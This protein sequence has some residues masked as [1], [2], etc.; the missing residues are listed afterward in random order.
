MAR[1]TS[2]KSILILSDLFPPYS[3]GG[4]EAVAYNLSREYLRMG[5]RV[6]VITT[7]QDR[8]LSGH[9]TEDGLEVHRLY[10]RLPDRFRAYWGL[11][12]PSV[13]RRTARIFKTL[14]P[15]MVHSHN[16][17]GHLSYDILRQAK[18]TGAYV[19]LTLHDAMSFDYGKCTQCIDYTDLSAN[20]QLHY[21]VSPWTTAK[22]YT[23]Y[24]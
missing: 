23:Q 12:N 21:Q 2:D 11:Y 15:A 5:H 8:S 22:T 20:P 7:V 1:P 10:T 9:V 16:V 3:E 19:V 18:A 14:R 13:L 17:H 4:S 6:H 24:S